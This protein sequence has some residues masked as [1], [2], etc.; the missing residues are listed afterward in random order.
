MV[1]TIYLI[2]F[3]KSNMEQQS[4]APLA[5]LS[6][7]I[8]LVTYGFCF[9]EL[10]IVK[11]N[12]NYYFPLAQYFIFFGKLLCVVLG[13]TVSMLFKNYIISV[14]IVLFLSTSFY[15]FIIV[16][17][18]KSEPDETV[19]IDYLLTKL[20]ISN[21]VRNFKIG[22]ITSLILLLGDIALIIFAVCNYS[23]NSDLLSTT[24]IIG[25]I[26]IAIIIFYINKLRKNRN[27]GSGVE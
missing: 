12:G 19:Y 9:Y 14:S 27:D 3:L 22:L 24:I 1:L 20:K 26:L 23:N 7:L 5:T 15:L 10:R 17:K 18:R 25:A 16:R 13:I 2:A 4:V 6:F 11:T 21:L 8:L